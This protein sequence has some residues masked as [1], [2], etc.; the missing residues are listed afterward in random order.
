MFSQC[1]PATPVS[2]SNDVQQ[3]SEEEEEVTAET[4]FKPEGAEQGSTELHSRLAGPQGDTTSLT[5]EVSVEQRLSI[6]FPLYLR[7]LHS[8]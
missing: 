5:Q 2:L 4:P 3:R 7:C 8:S 1:A 6:N